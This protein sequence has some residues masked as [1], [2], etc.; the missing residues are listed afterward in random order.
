V[1]VGIRQ[2]GE[3]GFGGGVDDLGGRDP[4]DFHVVGYPPK[5]VSKPSVGS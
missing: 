4:L 1:L 5:G 2:N 3:H